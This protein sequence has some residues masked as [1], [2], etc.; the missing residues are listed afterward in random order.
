MLARMAASVD[1]LSGGRLTL[2]VGAGWQEREHEKFGWD[3][4]PIPDRFE[5]FED[6]LEDYL[7]GLLKIDEPFILSRGSITRL[8]KPLLLPRPHAAWWPK[9]PDRGEWQDPD[10]ASG[11]Q[12]CR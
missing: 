6:G 4:L 11:S 12:I 2:G 3:L 5:R 1:D 7:R 9:D 10:D 8:M